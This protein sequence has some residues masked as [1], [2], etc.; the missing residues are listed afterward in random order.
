MDKLAL[1]ETELID[2][3]NQPCYCQ[4]DFKMRTHTHICVFDIVVLNNL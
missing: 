4:L 1:K 2:H 3:H